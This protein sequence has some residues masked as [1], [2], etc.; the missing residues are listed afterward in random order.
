MSID[1]ERR[2]LERRLK[3]DPNDEAAKKKLVELDRRSGLAAQVKALED[4]VT[5][6]DVARVLAGLGSGSIMARRQSGSIGAG[7]RRRGA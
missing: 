6:E 5:M 4:S 7:S 3:E 2:R 1:E